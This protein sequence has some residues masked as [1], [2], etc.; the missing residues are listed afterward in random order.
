LAAA[1]TMVVSSPGW[2]P[3]AEGTNGLL[4]AQS[5]APTELSPEEQ[6]TH[7]RV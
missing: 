1:L 6:A 4:I 7:R 2:L 3:A 5:A